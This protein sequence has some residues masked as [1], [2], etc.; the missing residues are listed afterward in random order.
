MLDSAIDGPVRGFRVWLTTN[1]STRSIVR[2]SSVEFVIGP[3]CSGVF[4]DARSVRIPVGEALVE[5]DA[6]T[7]RRRPFDEPIGQRDGSLSSSL[8]TLFGARTYSTNR[9]LALATGTAVTRTTAVSPRRRRRDRATAM[10]AMPHIPASSARPSRRSSRTRAT[11]SPPAR[12]MPHSTG[13]ATRTA[14]APRARAIRTSPPL[15]TPPS[16]YTSASPAPATT[17]GNASRVAI[18]RAS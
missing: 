4:D 12:A 14:R 17:S 15:R 10:S 8:R 2:P 3:S 6:E 13:R 18:D 7:G 1:V 9:A 11:P 16:R 5:G